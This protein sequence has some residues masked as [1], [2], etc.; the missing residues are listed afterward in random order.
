MSEA[1]FSAWNERTVLGRTSVQ[2]FSVA[3]GQGIP[4][5]LPTA[6]EYFKLPGILSSV[7]FTSLPAN[8]VSIA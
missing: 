8:A 1:T 2:F 3:G 5:D 6:H 7:L 4:F